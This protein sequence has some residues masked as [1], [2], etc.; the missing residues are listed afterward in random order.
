MILQ[1]LE[2]YYKRADLAPAG[3]KRQEIAFVLAI[4]RDGTFVQ[5]ESRIDSKWKRGMPMLVPQPEIRSGKDAWKQ[6]NLLWDHMGF[7][8]GS[9]KVTAKG[10]PDP[11]DDPEKVER[12]FGR[13]TARVG[14]LLERH[15]DSAGLRAVAAF[16]ARNQPSRVIV[17]V[18]FADVLKIPGANLTFRL[19]DSAEPVCQ[20]EWVSAELE[21]P[22][23][24]VDDKRASPSGICMLTGTTDHIARLHPKVAGVCEKPSALAA[25]NTLEFNA[26]SSY[27]KAQGHNFPVGDGAAFRYTTALNHLLAKDSAHRTRIGETTYVFWTEEQSPYESLFGEIVA[28]DPNRNTA[29]VAA[30]LSAIR[31]GR[32]S[33]DSNANRYYVCGFN[34]NAARVAVRV[35]HC[36]TV[37]DLGRRVQQHFDDTRIAHGKTEP[38]QLSL[39]RLLQSLC[40]VTNQHPF[41]DM[42]RLPPNLGGAVVDSIMAG[43]DVVYPANLLNA[44]VSRC[45]AEQ[46][47]NYARAAVLKACLNRLIR[48][49]AQEEE[50]IEMLDTSNP[51]AAYRIGR[52][53]AVLEKI[54]E[55]SSGGQ[56]RLN[57]TIR[58]R[59]YGAISSTPAS[60]LPLL[61]KLK[62]HHV[63]KLD[64]RGKAM[65]YRAFQDSRPDDYIGKIMWGLEHIPA[66]LPLHDQGRFAL[67]YYHQRQAFFSKIDP[68][69]TQEGN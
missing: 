33:N 56:G 45:R 42:E 37:Q 54:Q 63:G 29:T 20:E 50:F 61:C 6:P 30:T 8:L 40:P 36:M 58:D 15:P 1:A 52:L 9:V 38:D 3:W 67:G 64:D 19:I 39:K 57:S 27:G 41:G 21:S 17:D 10:A 44:A 53:F 25:A 5:I 31:T 26:Y 59:Y 12:Q 23:T 48:Q 46:S 22:D 7:L 55:E 14:A 13:F 2:R 4:E 34:P 35:F 43:P 24:D 49:H 69:V 68:A 60:L 51:N 65:L 62:N 66:H 11:T 28:D 47:V 32:L 16:Y 18:S